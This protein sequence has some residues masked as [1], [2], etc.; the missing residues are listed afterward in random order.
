MNTAIALIPEDPRRAEDV[1]ERLSGLLRASLDAQTRLVTLE[2]ELAVVT[3]YLEIERVRF[4]D[5]LRYEVSVPAELR[6]HEVPAFSLQ[7]LVENSVKYAVSA[8]QQGACIRIAARRDG[9]RLVIDVTD[10]GPGFGPNVWVPG[11]GLHELRARLDALYGD[12]ARLVA[13]AEVA[14]GAAVRIE[15]AA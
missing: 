9:D 4:A 7:T 6:S 15:M 2:T 8:R 12:R 13:P 11:H 1:L 5:R 3:D 10:D 14:A